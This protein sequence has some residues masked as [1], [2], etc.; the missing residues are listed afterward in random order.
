[1]A[2]VR[3]RQ[4]TP[5][6]LLNITDRPMPELVDGKLVERK[7]GEEADGIAATIIFLLNAFVRPRKLGKVGS[8]QCGFQI[9]PDKP[10]KVRI[11]DASFT[12]R[13]KMKDGPAKG[14]SKVV[15]D[16]V[17][18]VISPND[19][20]AD[21]L[22]KI[23]E[24]QSAGVPLIWVVNPESRTVR[25][26]LLNGSAPVFRVGDTLT[27]GEVLPGFECPVAAIFEDA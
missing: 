24:Y 19:Q 10:R 26:Y 17:V 3:E 6:D 9:F 5:E 21:V 18:E 14:H 8:S 2:S 20:A 23:D 22:A 7:M 16:L 15:P 13:E 12:R 11:P 25:P 1:M 27:G 4:Y